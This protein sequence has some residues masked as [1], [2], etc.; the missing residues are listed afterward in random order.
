MVAENVKYKSVDRMAELM[1]A[2]DYF[3]VV[4][5]QDS[6]RAISIN[7]KDSQRQGV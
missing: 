5:I 2:E 4:D 6:Y 7:P 1:K 3:A